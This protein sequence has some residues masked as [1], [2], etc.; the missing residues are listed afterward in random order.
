MSEHYGWNDE[1]WLNRPSGDPPR[2][3]ETEARANTPQRLG[4]FTSPLPMGYYNNNAYSAQSSMSLSQVQQNYIAPGTMFGNQPGYYNH[5]VQ[6]YPQDYGRG[7]SPATLSDPITSPQPRSYK[8]VFSVQPARPMS[9]PLSGRTESWTTDSTPKVRR[10]G[11]TRTIPSSP[12]KYNLIYSGFVSV[13]VRAPSNVFK[14]IFIPQ[15]MYSPNSEK[16]RQRFVEQLDIVPTVF[17]D[18]DGPFGRD[19]GISLKDARNDRFEYLLRGGVGAFPESVKSV[20]LRLEWPGY[21]AYGRQFAALDYTTSRN[22]ITREKLA[23]NIA[24]YVDEF[25]KKYATVQMRAGSNPIFKVGP[26]AITAD[27]LVLVSLHHVSQGSWQPQL[28]LM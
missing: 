12:V 20:T 26:G 2:P 9:T 13:P 23:K 8:T 22:P 16:D 6:D 1:F 17:F 3:S 19:W 24:K 25:I 4:S 11:S 27:D 14:N 10:R 7:V 28:R 15:V 18:T 5:G 21:D